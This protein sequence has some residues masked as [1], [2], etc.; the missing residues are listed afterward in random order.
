[1][2]RVMLSALLTLALAGCGFGSPVGGTAVAPERAAGTL[3]RW[4]HVPFQDPTRSLH[5]RARILPGG[6]RTQAVVDNYDQSSIVHLTIK[7]FTV[8][9]GTESPVLVDGNQVSAD[10]AAADLSRTV[11]LSN[12]K[13]DTTYRVRAYAY[14]AAGTAAADLIST[15]DASSHTDVALTNDD[16]PAMATLKVKLIDRVFDGRA[17]SG[18]VAVTSGGYTTSGPET[19]TVQ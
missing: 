1:M 14:K 9:G 4:A 11:T 8:S 3:A 12:L 6:I 15:S 7:L 19:I 10:L 17:S 16:R 5:L 18:A 2:R 13:V